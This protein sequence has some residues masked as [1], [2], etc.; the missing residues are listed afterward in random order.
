MLIKNEE[1]SKTLMNGCSGKLS[2]NLEDIITI[3][4]SGDLSYVVSDT[5][6]NSTSP[7]LKKIVSVND[8]TTVNANE[9][10]TG[11][12][13]ISDNK[14]TN[15]IIAYSN[16]G[17]VK[18]S[19]NYSDIKISSALSDATEN[20]NQKIVSMAYSDVDDRMYSVNSL[21]TLQF[22]VKNDSGD[23]WQLMYPVASE[24]KSEESKNKKIAYH[25]GLLYVISS[26]LTYNENSE[27]ISKKY[28][29]STIDIETGIN[30]TEK[31]Y[32]ISKLDEFDVILPEGKEYIYSNEFISIKSF[33]TETSLTTNENVLLFSFSEGF[34]LSYS[35][36][37]KFFSDANIYGN[38]LDSDYSK[39]NFSNLIK[40]NEER[41]SDRTF[42][43]DKLD[44]SIFEITNDISKFRNIKDVDSIKNTVSEL[45]E[46]Q[47]NEFIFLL[48]EDDKYSVN[49]YN[50]TLYNNGGTDYWIP[51]SSN[52]SGWGSILYNKIYINSVSNEN[53]VQNALPKKYV[54]GNYYK[55]D[56]ISN[57]NYQTT[58]QWRLDNICE[59]ELKITSSRF[60]DTTRNITY[61]LDLNNNIARNG[62]EYYNISNLSFTDKNTNVVYTV[63]NNESEKYVI[64]KFGIVEDK[65]AIDNSLQFTNEMIGKTYTI[66]VNE[67]KIICNDKSFDITDNS[68]TTDDEITYLLDFNKNLAYI[69]GIEYDYIKSK[70][71]LYFEKATDVISVGPLISEAEING[72]KNDYFIVDISDEY[73]ENSSTIVNYNGN[74]WILLQYDDNFIHTLTDNVILKIT[75]KNEKYYAT[76]SI[77]EDNNE[78]PNN[79]IFD[80]KLLINENGSYVI[81]N[82]HCV[83][84]KI[85]LS[86]DYSENKV[87]INATSSTN[88]YS[89]FADYCL[90]ENDNI[91]YFSNEFILEGTYEINDLYKYT[92]IP[93]V[94]KKDIGIIDISCKLKFEDIISNKN[95]TFNI[96]KNMDINADIR[97]GNVF[98]SDGISYVINYEKNNENNINIINI[99][100]GILDTNKKIV[101]EIIN[102]TNVTTYILSATEKY[103]E[104]NDKLY[105]EII[106][107][108]N[109]TYNDIFTFN[110]K[111]SGKKYYRRI[112]NDGNDFKLS[113]IYTIASGIFNVSDKTYVIEYDENNEPYK[114]YENFVAIENN[115][116]L[117]G[118]DYYTVNNGKIYTISNQNSIIYDSNDSSIIK[119]IINLQ[120][121]FEYAD[122]FNDKNCC[123][124][125][126]ENENSDSSNKICYYRKNGYLYEIAN[127]NIIANK[128]KFENS[129]YYFQDETDNTNNKIYIIEKE[130]V[131]D[132]ETD[133]VNFTIGE[134]SYY[135]TKDNTIYKEVSD[136][137]N[138]NEFVINESLYYLLENKLYLVKNDKYDNKEFYKTNY[139]IYQYNKII[140]F[141]N[142]YLVLQEENK[143][144]KLIENNFNNTVS[145][146]NKTYYILDSKVYEIINDNKNYTIVA[147]DENNRDVHIDMK[148]INEYGTKIYY[149]EDNSIRYY[150]S[151]DNTIPEVWYEDSNNVVIYLNVNHSNDN[152]ICEINGITY[153]IDTTNFKFYEKYNL[154]DD[155][156]YSIDNLTDIETYYIYE[157][158]ETYRKCV[159]ISN[160]ENSYFEIENNNYII[161]N[162]INASSI[163]KEM[164]IAITIDDEINYFTDNSINYYFTSEFNLNSICT[165]YSGTEITYDNN[166]YK[167]IKNDN[168]ICYICSEITLNDNIFYIEYT[169]NNI[170]FI[171]IYYIDTNASKVY[172]II[173]DYYIFNS[174]ENKKYICSYYADI[175]EN[176]L[177]EI[178]TVPYYIIKYDENI[179]LVKNR[180]EIDENN[181]FEIENIQYTII[182][183]DDIDYVCNKVSDLKHDNNG[184]YFVINGIKNYSYS[185][186]I[187]SEI[188]IDNYGVFEINEIDYKI[189]SNNIVINEPIA[190]NKTPYDDYYG[191]FTLNNETYQIIILNGN[192]FINYNIIFTSDIEH[193]YLLKFGNNYY[194]YDDKTNCIYNRDYIATIEDNIFIIE[195][196]KYKVQPILEGNNIVN[197][198]LSNYNRIEDENITKE[199]IFNYNPLAY[200]NAIVLESKYLPAFSIR[201][202]N[203]NF[204]DKFDFVFTY[205]NESPKYSFKERMTLVN[206]SDI[207]S[208]EIKHIANRTYFND[209]P[210]ENICIYDE[211]KPTYAFI[212]KGKNINDLYGTY[213]L[214]SDYNWK[215]I[216]SMYCHPSI[217][218]KDDFYVFPTATV[219][220]GDIYFV[221][222]NHIEI[223]DS[224]DLI[225]PSGFYIVVSTVSD[226]KK[227]FKLLWYPDNETSYNP[228][229]TNVVHDF[230]FVATRN[231]IYC[232]EFSYESTGFII[233]NSTFVAPELYYNGLKIQN[234][235]NRFTTLK[236]ETTIP[237]IVYLYKEYN[238]STYYI[239][240]SENIIPLEYITMCDFEEESQYKDIAIS[241]KIDAI[242]DINDEK[243]QYNATIV[244]NTLKNLLNMFSYYDMKDFEVLNNYIF[245]GLSSSIHSF[246]GSNTNNGIVLNAIQLSINNGLTFTTS[247]DWII[248]NISIDEKTKNE[249]ISYNHIDAYQYVYEDESGEKTNKYGMSL[250][251]NAGNFLIT[252][253]FPSK[254]LELENVDE[255]LKNR[256]TDNVHEIYYIVDMIAFKAYNKCIIIGLFN[257]NKITL[258]Y[259]ANVLNNS[260]KFYDT[261]ELPEDREFKIP[262][263]IGNTHTIYD[264]PMYFKNNYSYKSYTSNTSQWANFDL[265]ISNNPTDNTDIITADEYSSFN[266]IFLHAKHNQLYL[267]ITSSK[268]YVMF[269]ELNP[270]HS[271][272]Y[273]SI[274]PNGYKNGVDFTSTSN[275]NYGM[276]YDGLTNSYI[277]EDADNPT[278]SLKYNAVKIINDISKNGYCTLN[279]SE[280]E[281][282]TVEPLV[283]LLADTFKETKNENG[284]TYSSDVKFNDEYWRYIKPNEL[285][286]NNSTN[287]DNDN[288]FVNITTVKTNI[289]DIYVENNGQNIIRRN[290]I[291]FG[292]YKISDDNDTNTMKSRVTIVNCDNKL[293]ELD[294]NILNVAIDK[295][296]P[297]NKNYIQYAFRDSNSNY[298][299]YDYIT[300]SH[301]VT[302]EIGIVTNII[303]LCK[304]GRIISSNR[305]I[306]T[307]DTSEWIYDVY[308]KEDI[309]NLVITTLNDDNLIKSFEWLSMTS[310]PYGE[311]YATGKHGIV[312]HSSDGVTFDIQR[313]DFDITNIQYNPETD[314]IEQ[315]GTDHLDPDEEITESE[316][317]TDENI[318]EDFNDYDTEE[319]EN[320]NIS[321]EYDE[322]SVNEEI[323]INPDAIYV[324]NTD[325][326]PLYP[327]N[328]SNK[329][330]N[331]INNTLYGLAIIKN[332]S[333]E[334]YSDYLNIS[335]L[336]Q[337]EYDSKKS[338]YD[339]TLYDYEVNPIKYW[340]Y[341]TVSNKFIEI[342]DIKNFDDSYQYIPIRKDVTYTFTIAYYIGA[343]K[344]S[345]KFS[346]KYNYYNDYYSSIKG[347]TTVV[348]NKN[349]F[350]KAYEELKDLKKQ[351]IGGTEKIDIDGNVIET[352]FGYNKI[353]TFETTYRIEPDDIDNKYIKIIP[354]YKYIFNGNIFN[355]VY[356]VV[357]KII[358]GETYTKELNGY[359]SSSFSTNDYILP[360][361]ETNVT[362]IPAYDIQNKTVVE[363][364]INICG[365]NS[366]EFETKKLDEELPYY[367]DNLESD[368][369][370][371]FLNNRYSKAISEKIEKL[372]E[373]DRENAESNVNK[374]IGIIGAIEDNTSNNLH[375]F[376]SA[377]VKCYDIIKSIISKRSFDVSTNVTN[378][379]TTNENLNSSSSS[380]NSVSQ[381]KLTLVTFSKSKAN[382]A[383]GFLDLIRFIRTYKAI[384]EESSEYLGLIGTIISSK[385]ETATSSGESLINAYNTLDVDGL[386]LY[387]KKAALAYKIYKRALELRDNSK[388]AG[389]NDCNDIYLSKIAQSL[390]LQYGNYFNRIRWTLWTIQT[391]RN[392]YERLSRG[393]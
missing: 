311:F 92:N 114:I 147:I 352:Y 197:Y 105:A 7:I 55:Y 81:K 334:N 282:I 348:K 142:N 176:N 346:F 186:Y 12:L 347:N 172:Q 302:N 15:D 310:T 57:S 121:L 333:D 183:I 258:F 16:D 299:E 265:K 364:A 297:K 216:D 243:K 214:E 215:A 276:F 393:Y 285:F 272:D 195:N 382:V 139:N 218:I 13:S 187:S 148:C 177:I 64:G 135:I 280:N 341:D 104:L 134:Y 54:H 181:S 101:N 68:F 229:Y 286:L 175:N 298:K 222:T 88:L 211:N 385:K 242:Y 141:E 368:E 90:S 375:N 261:E 99:D 325:I 374:M 373:E 196:I 264:V 184:Y 91:N 379:G 107:P 159:K 170:D 221:D 168:N 108:N 154:N 320:I 293:M 32:E 66:N 56:D 44:D 351:F 386:K 289:W 231:Y 387:S 111:Y 166:I 291:L 340:K 157:I 230:I 85:V 268:G 169:V 256:Y 217:E 331:I 83:Y 119:Y 237:T 349:E 113:E 207:D 312:I 74:N 327:T 361:D 9:T 204:T 37:P 390:A 270:L 358:N 238:N 295:S 259:G 266:N 117:I 338:G 43:I 226:I 24:N 380:D 383:Y 277:Y 322:T 202:S 72:G 48:K 306:Y 227:R 30:I 163:Y 22:Y 123:E 25:N 301:L 209:I 140:D 192:Y 76:L 203:N 130:I 244:S 314:D 287:I 369:Y 193:N 80:Y 18:T 17:N 235:G 273:I 1:I 239:K 307:D 78:L 251:D 316:V 174:D 8:T 372:F 257:S 71:I 241:E 128:N 205:S 96:P 73:V 308:W 201:N 329:T 39:C 376:I 93:S 31:K 366:I 245:V 53:D 362:V 62:Y 126:V 356:K 359:T 5:T 34:F 290:I 213:I 167:I 160:V 112:Y 212:K 79:I 2:T 58:Y 46:V 232:Y 225:Y 14:K 330:F 97:Y 40:G 103:Y 371:K 115:K 250:F 350:I 131:F 45:P 189:I 220:V 255:Y 281:K 21:G 363:R 146:N 246:S 60:T 240:I 33:E 38:V 355:G 262:C 59:V 136:L 49:Q 249:L 125:K 284:Y 343:T 344:K 335:S 345:K 384:Y 42:S 3:S 122:I 300:H 271:D 69:S 70:E 365:K 171:K 161:V 360:N 51:Y 118:S 143:I 149:F 10:Y 223:S 236:S 28:S 279:F 233:E 228:Y 389:K 67:G 323:E 254:E 224:N 199:I 339:I 98:T 65:F 392:H 35:T 274:I 165:L 318:F 253:T 194:F 63:Y 336:K 47:Q 219:N 296:N 145:I 87:D 317:T 275:P 50:T 173:T 52:N 144:R 75:K 208:S 292:G 278:I 304:S 152:Y 26:I 252:R 132:D 305:I 100:R 133:K 124:L 288:F 188:E 357:E 191:Y 321:P 391:F 20:E 247:C 309:E 151:Y 41:I 95:V 179:Y 269:R 110:D 164:P 313:L 19:F 260:T 234:I 86:Y 200:D 150:I 378:Y 198:I 155:N 367:K 129:Y 326:F 178:G 29:I 77:V 6:E 267:Y 206:S 210:T 342:N 377:Y 263:Y 84:N 116:F 370:I 89:L 182:T 388:Y 23:Y 354:V 332:Y 303:L 94:I 294:E 102:T 106:K 248:R 185:E 82:Y 36:T 11:I 190:I 319:L 120:T 353:K 324:D 162:D 138:S 61:I 283:S 315:Y 337:K 180:I 156:S 4:K 109:T 137:N 127:D 27:I 381:S 153:Y 158:N 328:V